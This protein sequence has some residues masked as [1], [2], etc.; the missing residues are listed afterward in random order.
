MGIITNKH[1]LGGTTF[2]ILKIVNSCFFFNIDG[3]KVVPPQ[4]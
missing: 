4:F 3:Y 2:P 1:N